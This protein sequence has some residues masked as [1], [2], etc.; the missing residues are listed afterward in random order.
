MLIVLVH[1]ISKGT[2]VDSN[3]YNILLFEST[4][5]NFALSQHI[6]C[7]SKDLESVNLK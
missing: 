1:E 6:I 7:G 2:K 3:V 5:K 4:K